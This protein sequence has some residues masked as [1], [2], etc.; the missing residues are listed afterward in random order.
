MLIF[1]RHKIINLSAAELQERQI[2]G[3]KPPNQ[4]CVSDAVIDVINCSQKSQSYPPP[5]NEILSVCHKMLIKQCSQCCFP[6]QTHYDQLSLCLPPFH[7]EIIF[8]QLHLHFSFQG[9]ISSPASKGNIHLSTSVYFIPGAMENRSIILK[10]HL[11]P[12]I[13][14][15]KE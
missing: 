14:W 9:D 3:G 4:K 13:P 8:L 11:D 5:T 6:V 7:A 12:N 15:Q 2:R 1:S 10:D